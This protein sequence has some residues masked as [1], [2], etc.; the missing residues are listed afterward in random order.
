MLEDIKGKRVLVTGSSTGIGA[1]M[2]V[3][4][5]RLGA[6]VAVHGN[7]SLDQAQKIVD[8]ITASGGKAVLVSGDVSDKTAAA[9]IVADAVEGLGGL[10]VLINN[11]GGIIERVTNTD[12][13]DDIYDKVYDPQKPSIQ[14]RP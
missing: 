4:F 12:F 7:R 2:A 11:A 5:G 1:A 14:I 8:T 9:K 6:S 13:D 10:D 3:E